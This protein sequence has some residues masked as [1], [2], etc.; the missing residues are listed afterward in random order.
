MRN[1]IGIL[2][3][4]LIVTQASGQY[5]TRDAG[6]RAGEGFF[7]TYRQFFHENMAVEGMVGFSKNGFRLIGLRE[8]FSTL[9]SARSDNLKL[10]YGYGIHAGVTYTNKYKFLNKVYYHDWMWTP[11]FGIDGAFG[12][13]YSASEFPFLISAAIQPYFEFSLNRYFCLKPLNFIIAVKYRF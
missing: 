13:E 10:L 5:Y 1:T 3:F 7:L 6:V 11:Q 8:Y 4:L 12:L 9:A 2:V